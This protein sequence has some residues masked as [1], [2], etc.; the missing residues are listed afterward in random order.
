[1]G[2]TVQELWLP[3]QQ[4]CVS[5]VTVAKGPRGNGGW[6]P[7]S[8]WKCIPCR[9]NKTQMARNTVGERKRCWN[10]WHRDDS[11]YI[12]RRYDSWYSTIKCWCFVWIN[13]QPQHTLCPQLPPPSQHMFLWH[14][15]TMTELGHHT[16]LEHAWLENELRCECSVT[17]IFVIVFFH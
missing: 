9:P 2:C 3:R 17:S 15:V 12:A 8:L 11:M 5:F 1:M 13:L 16:P 6:Q 14:W 7:G 4:H 10:W